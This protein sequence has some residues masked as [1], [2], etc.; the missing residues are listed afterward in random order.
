LD[1]DSGCVTI[2]EYCVKTVGEEDKYIEL[3][4]IPGDNNT[5]NRSDGFHFVVKGGVIL[6]TVAF[7][8]LHS[9]DLT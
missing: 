2:E 7:D 5:R 3:L 4:G 9:R 8:K 1:D 6:L